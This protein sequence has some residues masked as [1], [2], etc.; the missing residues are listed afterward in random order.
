MRSEPP[1][2]SGHGELEE[3]AL[4]CLRMLVDVA[5]A[6]AEAGVDYRL[7]GGWSVYAHAEE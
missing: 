5:T 2:V 4:A 7:I 3:V 6:L 1:V